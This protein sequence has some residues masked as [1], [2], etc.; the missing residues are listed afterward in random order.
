M[1]VSHRLAVIP[2][3]HM[4]HRLLD[5]AVRLRG[6][7]YDVC[8]LGDYVDNGPHANDPGFLREL[9]GFCREARATPLLGNHDLAYVFPERTD[10]RI[11]GYEPANAAA[12]ATVYAEYADLFRY[13]H[14]VDKV[15]LTHAGMSRTFLNALAVT[16]GCDDLDEVV[17]YLNDRRPAELFFRSRHNGGTDAFDGPLWLRLPQYHG[18]LQ[19]EG[20]TQVV[21]H[22]SQAT[23]RSRFNLLMIDVKRAL[24]M[25]W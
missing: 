11:N 1:R 21:G 18:A 15:L 22:S 6:E 12:V 20:I 19:S 10:Y 13:A 5:E 16:Y 2:D 4:R 24:V 25:E 23:I 3:V 17:A 8:F 9:F 7:G 14:R